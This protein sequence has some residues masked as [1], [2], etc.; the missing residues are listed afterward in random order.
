MKYLVFLIA[1]LLSTPSFAEEEK[2]ELNGFLQPKPVVC[3]NGMEFF[4][5]ISKSSGEVPFASWT[6]EESGTSSLMMINK[7]KNT[8]TILE[9]MPS[10]MI[11]CITGVGVNFE[12]VD[13]ENKK[14][15]KGQPVRYLT[16]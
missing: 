13:D 4:T 15:I 3:G 14:E 16:K 6:S 7:V 1:L 5:V 12:F 2:P 11:S 10:G 8:V 9:Y